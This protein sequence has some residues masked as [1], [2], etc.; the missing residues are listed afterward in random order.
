MLRAGIR[1]LSG[2]REPLVAVKV[3]IR[4]RQDTNLGPF[5]PENVPS[6][7]LDEAGD[8]LLS[9][10]VNWTH[11]PSLALY[12]AFTKMLRKMN[13]THNLQFF[14]SSVSLKTPGR[15]GCELN[16]ACAYTQ[17]LLFSFCSWDEKQM[18]KTTIVQVISIAGQA[19]VSAKHMD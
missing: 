18:I 4:Q 9:S 15:F 13:T 3:C 11:V 8:P 7:A 14:F 1:H 12:A 17:R 6:A 2:A 16:P 10:F 19:V 5:R